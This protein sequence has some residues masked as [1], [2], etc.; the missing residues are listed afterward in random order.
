MPTSNRPSE[1]VRVDQSEKLQYPDR[2]VVFRPSEMPD[3]E[4]DEIFVAAIN[5]QIEIH[6][7]QR[8]DSA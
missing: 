4:A 5:H 7:K 2:G 8:D 6:Q 3:K 1:P